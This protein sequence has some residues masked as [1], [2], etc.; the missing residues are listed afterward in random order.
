MSQPGTEPEGIFNTLEAIRAE[1]EGRQRALGMGF[2]SLGEKV[3]AAYWQADERLPKPA[4]A[5]T[6]RN[7]L[8]GK[9]VLRD[10][11]GLELYFIELG[12]SQYEMK[13]IR[14]TLQ[15]ELDRRLV[16]T[17]Q[18][19]SL[20]A[21]D[22]VD[23]DAMPY[24]RAL[25]ECE[26]ITKLE[27]SIDAPITHLTPREYLLGPKGQREAGPDPERWGL[28]QHL[29]E[30]ARYIAK[31][32]QV[33][34][35]ELEA[36]PR[37][38]VRRRRVQA[39]ADLREIASAYVHWLLYRPRAADLMFSKRRYMLHGAFPEG[40][41]AAAVALAKRATRTLF[42]VVERLALEAILQGKHREQRLRTPQAE[43][44]M[45]AVS[46]RVFGMVSAFFLMVVH[47]STGTG[48][49][50]QA[51][52]Q[53]RRENKELPGAF[54]HVHEQLISTYDDA[55]REA[56]RS[57]EEDARVPYG[58]LRRIYE[59]QFED[60]RPAMVEIWNR[61]YA[62]HLVRQTV[63]L[64]LGELHDAGVLSDKEFV[65]LCKELQTGAEAKKALLAKHVNIRYPRL[66][67]GAP[68]T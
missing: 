23:L 63:S 54:T 32:D 22:D 67:S 58:K 39:Y 16:G 60:N 4:S 48:A 49:M 65:A 47:G 9:T 41:R 2:H 28:V 6:F 51:I 44:A 18:Q 57:L 33:L 53:L 12:A 14:S 1:F 56:N 3:F 36:L 43:R 52:Y 55:V 46:E 64:L 27:D 8:Q 19:T 31:L 35:D 50:F 40:Q 17:R 62:P 34:A 29:D 25:V 38:N 37:S 68:V 45:E 24:S 10:P 15:R 30:F 66:D 20:R 21:L 59:R 42:G 7:F 61:D 26:V 5:M 11:T 13:L